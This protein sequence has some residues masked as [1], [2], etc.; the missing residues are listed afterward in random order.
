M[1]E[2]K[3]LD[4]IKHLQKCKKMAALIPLKSVN[5]YN[6]FESH[7]VML[8]EAE[9]EMAA[10]SSILAWRTPRTEETGRLQSMGSQ[11]VI[12]NCATHKHTHTHSEA[13]DASIL[14]M[15]NIP[16]CP[17]TLNPKRCAYICRFYY[18]L[19]Y[20]LASLSG[21]GFT[22]PILWFAPS[23]AK[24]EDTEI[25]HISTWNGP[26]ILIHMEPI[27]HISNTADRGDIHK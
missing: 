7:L 23:C 15:A 6:N 26:N 18:C 27:L 11:R 25:L 10:H 14:P 24:Q 22:T 3:S 8:S 19:W 13:E 21:Q 16:E 20:Q 4:N 12:N 1:A 2:V 9:K 17:C 5:Q